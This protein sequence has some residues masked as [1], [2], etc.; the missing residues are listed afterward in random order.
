[1]A[2]RAAT[3]PGTAKVAPTLTPLKRVMKESPKDLGKYQHS[4]AK[5]T[6][7]LSISRI[8]IIS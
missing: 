7:S 8:F 2:S 4:F 6:A 5:V 1:M 3:V